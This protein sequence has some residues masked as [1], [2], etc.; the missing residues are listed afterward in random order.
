MSERLV[1][2]A[3]AW[4]GRT[5]G[6]RRLPE[7]H[8]QSPWIAVSIGIDWYTGCYGLR[9]AFVKVP[10]PPE[11]MSPYRWQRFWPWIMEREMR[12]ES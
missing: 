10:S 7:F 6:W 2:D 11:Y 8:F 9:I 1:F 5:S 4:T 3:S 12:A